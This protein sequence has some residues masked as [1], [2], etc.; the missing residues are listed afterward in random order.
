M[1]ADLPFAVV[2]VVYANLPVE[3][4]MKRRHVC[5]AWREGEDALPADHRKGMQIRTDEY[6][7]FRC[8]ISELI[9]GMTFW[10]K[11]HAELH[12]EPDITVTRCF[13]VKLDGWFKVSRYGS[14][15][16]YGNMRE[17][18]LKLLRLAPTVSHVY[19]IGDY[20]FRTLWESNSRKQI[21]MRLLQ[22]VSQTHS[23][24]EYKSL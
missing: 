4:L 18:I 3:D 6:R 1:L 22:N 14:P 13:V 17:T 5:K 9:K 8:C 12:D 24:N 19:T 20:W 7:S 16:E 21:R 2:E 23:M 15:D 11:F 10:E